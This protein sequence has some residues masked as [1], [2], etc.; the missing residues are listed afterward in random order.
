MRRYEVDVHHK[1]AR[2][3]LKLPRP[4]QARVAMRIDALADEP[5]PPGVEKLTDTRNGYRIRSGDY[6]IVYTVDDAIPIVKVVRVTHRR[7][8]YRSMRHG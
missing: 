3:I 7:E 5:R 1:A 2:A 8:V 6:R 4:D